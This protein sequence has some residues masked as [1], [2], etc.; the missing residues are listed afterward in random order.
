[1]ATRYLY[2]P[3]Y[4]PRHGVKIG[5]TGEGAAK[6]GAKRVRQ[7]L[8][9]LADWADECW[10]Q[11]KKLYLLLFRNQADFFAGLPKYKWAC[12]DPRAPEAAAVLPTLKPFSVVPADSPL[13]VIAHGMDAEDYR[14]Q[15][16]TEV[17]LEGKAP[18]VG[19]EWLA[20]HFASHGLRTHHRV[21]KLFI[22]LSAAGGSGSFAARFFRAMV[23]ENGYQHLRVYGYDCI[24]VNPH[25]DGSSR[26]GK[27]G[28]DVERGVEDLRFIDSGQAATC[29]SFRYFWEAGGPNAGTKG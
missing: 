2:T 4:K 18:T 29:K 1:M 21:I 12:Y 3:F 16:V 22:C 14:F 28:F 17:G 23:N 26:K 9:T 6:M 19:P 5:K 24:T 20:D 25:I 8:G 13:Y 10:N 27:P 7:H 15:K 11:D